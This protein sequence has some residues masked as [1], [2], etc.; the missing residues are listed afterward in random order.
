MN[1]HQISLAP[2]LQALES[3][4][5]ALKQPKNEFI[6]DSVIQRFEYTFELCWKTLL[7]VLESDKPLEDR[8][9]R[10]ILRTAHNHG[11]IDQLDLW[12]KMHEAR[13]LTSHTYNQKTAEE[14]YNVA[15]GLQERALFLIQ[16]IQ[17]RIAKS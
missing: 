4:Q 3:L 9:I 16:Q 10:E 2:L 5:N 6:R 1:I 7:K 17:K 15:L 14:V 13:N 8:S 12:F 11:L